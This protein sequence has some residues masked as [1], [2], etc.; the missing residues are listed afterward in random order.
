[1]N[2]AIIITSYVIIDDVM[3]S[4]NHRSHPLAKVS[5]A[6][7][8]TV[9][10]VAA[11]YFHNN[12]ER[13]LWV[14]TELGYLS[15]RLSTSRFNRRLHAIAD[16]LRLTVETLGELFAQGAVCIIDSMPL[17]V[18]RRAR[19]R[20][21]RK[22]RGRDYCAYCA[23]KREKFFGFR[24]HLV[25]TPAGLPVSF[26]IVAGGYHDLTSLHELTFALP[27]GAC[28]F[29]DKGDNSAPDE[30]TIFAET[31][32]RVIPI[33]RKNMERHEW[34]DEFDLKQYRKVIESVNSQLE[35]MGTQHLHARTNIGFEV[36][37]HASLLALACSNIN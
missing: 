20:R 23:A 31:G 4:L 37:V 6:E 14:L 34:T 24:L 25:C 13:A 26:A 28:V 8:L 33:R 5:D 7:V 2:D 21:N 22:V 30:A 35:K 16:W 17:P 12:H 19:A 10:V 29:G 3:R 32:V 36:K 9:A 27:D 15:E 11:K 1:M 18:C